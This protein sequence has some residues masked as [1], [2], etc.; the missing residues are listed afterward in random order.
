MIP[1]LVDLTSSS[2][3]VF[4]KLNA[5][6]VVV[7]GLLFTKLSIGFLEGLYLM[8]LLPLIR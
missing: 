5:F 3:H 1:Q 2:L 6:F 7:A 4:N 8:L